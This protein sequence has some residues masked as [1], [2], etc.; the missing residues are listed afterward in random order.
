MQIDRR[1]KSGM[2]TAER[3]SDNY[4]WAH[5][6]GSQDGYRRLSAQNL[7][8]AAAAR[9]APAAFLRSLPGLRQALALNSRTLPLLAAM[10][11]VAILTAVTF[12]AGA[13]Y[14]YLVF[15]HLPWPL[16]YLAATFGVAA[17]FV[18]Q[19]S[20]ARD[21]S[22]KRLPDARE[23]IRSVFRRWNIAFSLFVVVLFMIQA[24]DFYSRGSIISQYVAGL[25]AAMF[26]RL[27][28]SRIVDHWLTRGVI[29]GR[30][31]VVVGL[32]T[33]MKDLLVRLR[34][35]GPGAEIVDTISLSAQSPDGEN[36]AFRRVEMLAR[37]IQIDE[38]VIAL[39]W[40]EH[41]RIRA[42][43]ERLSAIPATIHLAPDP[44]W[45]WIREPVLARVGRT[46]TLRL[47]RAPLTLKD[48]GLKRLFDVVTAS[49][50]LMVA[51]PALALIAL[52]IRLDSPGPVLFRQ[53][54][55]GFNQR[56]FR[57][58]KFRTMS[59]LDDGEVVRQ[60]QVNDSR[61]T[62]VG[63]ILRRTNLDEVP[64][65]L[66]VIMG[67]MSLVGPRP[68][69]VAHNTEYEERIRLYARRHNVKPGITGWAQ[70]N[71]LRGETSTI[72]KM[73]QRV[74]HDLYYI[75][76]WSVPFDLKIMLMTLFSP[77]SYRNAY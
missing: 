71:G 15:D 48:R 41:L 63:R 64:Q 9:Q 16:F 55:N 51:A 75:D 29:R 45:V 38:I 59:T 18:L 25:L 7:W 21:H 70:V 14:H 10:A 19:C 61:V 2:A 56:E 31:V 77:R 28:L 57:V 39:P 22:I 6:S 52:A 35:D 12:E 73:A 76:H 32:A 33:N 36:E 23:Q 68:H 44:S 50:L 67:D 66:N 62:R 11:E 47:S 34:Q 60:A 8:R 43:V 53:R 37:R 17:V 42:L 74:E 1:L 49:A 13:V 69:A 5:P 58:F 54:R 30:K 40:Q 46:H 27:A 65:L 24:T 20:L 3:C 26:L 72:D 4:G